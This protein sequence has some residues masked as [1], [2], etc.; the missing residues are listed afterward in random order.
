MITSGLMSSNTD[1]WAT[2]Q[3][4]FDRLNEEFHFTLDVCADD[5]NHKVDRYFDESVDGLSK[6]W[7]KD[8]SWMN[9]PYGRM[10]PM[11]VRKAVE[12]ARGGGV[13]VG[14]LPA[15]TDTRWW[16]DVMQ[17]TELR[18]IKGRVRFGGSDSG[19][20]FPSVVAIWGTPRVPIISV[21]EAR[22]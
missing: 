13:V 8:I 4:L 16:A 21:M 5:T 12:T 17:A 18:F 22:L 7:T 14:L 15:R 1:K 19:A 9:P 11:W 20:P 3:D 6:D 2:P 10:I